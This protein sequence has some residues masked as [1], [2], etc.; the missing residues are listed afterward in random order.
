MDY[1]QWY[2]IPK[3]REK[4]MEEYKNY[5]ILSDGKFGNR[6]IQMN[7]SGKLPRMLRGVYTSPTHAK[8]AIDAYV[9]LKG[10]KNAE[11][12]KSSRA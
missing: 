7:G 5:R 10:N 12:D 8:L 1:P 4:I 9:A 2:E 6:Y 3:L 11:A